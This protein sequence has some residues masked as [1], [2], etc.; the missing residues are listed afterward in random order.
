MNTAPLHDL[1]NVP[2]GGEAIFVSA[3]D[4][5]KIRIAYWQGGNR[6][7]VLLL[8]GRTEYIEKYGRVVSKL[9]DRN[10]NVVIIDWRGQGLSFRHDGRRDRGYVESFAHYQQ[11]IAA[12][13]NA[14]EIMAL[15]GP[16]L[17]F[18]HSMGGCIGLRALVGG[19]DV[20]GAV[21][22]SPMWGVPGSTAAKFV[23]SVVST[24]GRPFG[25]HKAL[26]PGK[27]PTYY[28]SANPFEG[29]ELTNDPE[30]YAMFKSHLED[31]PDLG[32]GGPTIH[33][34]A[35]AIEEMKALTKA[36]VPDIPILTFMGTEEIVVDGE[37]IK[38]RAPTFPDTTLEI[39][40]GSKHEVWME[41]P[42]I[43]TQVWD[44]TDKFLD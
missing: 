9:Q 39:L 30:Y 23:L 14:S 32:L 6:G 29:N 1:L 24:L 33:W 20:K 10:L 42:E 34:A 40:A 36:S 31:Q 43:Q 35:K 19:L 41:Q 16:R 44:I 13:I 21:F 15:E 4:G 26:V 25:Q 8:P 28:A 22:S 37:A 17:L 3:Q 18:A 2:A 7:T 27:E 5:T 12:A 11:D 38:A